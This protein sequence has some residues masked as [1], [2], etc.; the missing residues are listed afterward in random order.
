MV[1]PAPELHRELEAKP[2]AMNEG[3]S[4]QAPGDAQGARIVPLSDIEPELLVGYL[5][6]RGIA[7]PTVRWKYFEREFNRDRERGFVALRDNQVVGFLGSIPVKLIR[8]DDEQADNWLCDW[9]I[10]DPERDR[11]LGGALAK[12]AL[13]AT[14]RMIAFGGTRAAQARWPRYATRSDEE[15]GVV[16]RKRLTL[17]SYVRWLQ[18]RRLLPRSRLLDRL[19]LIPTARLGEASGKCTVSRGARVPDSALQARSGHWRPT[20]GQEDLDWQLNRCPEVESWTVSGGGDA[21]LAWRSVIDPSEWRFAIL[22]GGGEPEKVRDLLDCALRLV[23]DQGGA[24]VRVLVSRTDDDL[25][26]PL[27]RAGFAKGRSRLPIHFVRI[28]PE[29]CPS[30]LQRL[31]YLDTDLGHRF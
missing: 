7:E 27:V 18:S 19:G 6:R 25:A 16:Y 1:F 23:R 12:A 31:S 11:G 15:A 10:Q 24:T 17:L 21:L 8:G 5:V 28:D 26:G 14:G 2:V 4:S 30:T 20:Y 3:R 9:S 13:S 29:D 22:P